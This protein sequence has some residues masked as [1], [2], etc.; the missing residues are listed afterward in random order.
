LV[1]FKSVSH[2]L[3]ANRY[4]FYRYL[5][6]TFSLAPTSRFRH[7]GL[8]P[9]PQGFREWLAK[10][11]QLWHEQGLLQ[12]G[13]RDQILARYPE[14]PPGMSRMAFVLRAF[15]V[16]LLGAA[17]MLVIGHNWSDLSRGG[18]L[19]TVV[20]GVALLQGIGL[21]YTFQGRR[22]G[23]VLGHLAG[24]LMFGAGIA[25]VG[26][27]YHMDA[28]SPDAVLAWCLATL[29]FALVLESTLLHVATVALAA[30]W[31]L[32]E[33][34]DHAGATVPDLSWLRLIFLLLLL[35]SAAAAYRS[36]SPVIAGAVAWSL[37]AYWFTYVGRGAALSGFALPLALAAL[38]PAGNPNARGFRF[39]GALGVT[40]ITLY[41]GMLSRSGSWGLGLLGDPVMLTLTLLAVGWALRTGYKEGDASRTWPAFIALGTLALGLLRECGLT[42]AVS[43]ALTKALANLLTIATAVW[44]IRTG[45]A[46][47]RLRPY[48]YGSLVFLA[49]LT[50]RYVD[51]AQ[52]FGMLGTAGFFAVI[53]VILFILARVWRAQKEG[54]V[55]VVDASWNPAWLDAAFARLTSRARPILLAGAMLQAAGLLWMAW[56]HSRP[57]ETG[58]RFLLRCQALDPRD[59]MKGEYVILGY[60]FSRPSPEDITGLNKEWGEMH[61]QDRGGSQREPYWMLP[62]D[63]E[64]Y[65][66]LAVDAKGVAR[67]GRP[68]LKRPPTG[69]YLR[70][71]AGSRR[72]GLMRFGIEA[73]YVKEGEGKGWENLRDQGQLVAEVGVLP[74]GR[75]G[76]IGLR[77]A[78]ASLTQAAPFHR[79]EQHFYAGKESWAQRRVLRSQ[80]EFAK[81][82]SPARVMGPAP[83]LPDFAKEVVLL[84]VEPDTNRETRITVTSVERFGAS[85]IA[86]YRVTTGA[87]IS[88]RTRPFEAIILERGDAAEV[89]LIQEGMPGD[90]SMRLPLR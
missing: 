30:T 66:P 57:A 72:F 2:S 23:S 14:E 13:Q 46:E 75:A 39:I 8:M 11:S 40:V 19:A 6:G 76:L 73:F 62:D 10:E 49:W 25:L 69:P 79:L 56:H 26:Q 37:A 85:L 12:P 51:I 29:P 53:G 81:T 78:E 9:L 64:I 45:L 4:P 63:T 44:L 3:T 5:P 24:C 20:A 43:M 67:A 77:K 35:P 47:G 86:R 31:M 89:T 32:M 38:H 1:S 41:A 7:L 58:Q 71:H 61:G 34:G 27:T 48:V 87:A 55:S 17:V 28:H 83:R 33:V 16:L 15:G 60:E 90:R 50:A 82:L 21:W 36:R 84:I 68:T 65:L 42:S 74:D 18:R 52:D 70:G 80:A 54:F 59:L 22:T 88:H